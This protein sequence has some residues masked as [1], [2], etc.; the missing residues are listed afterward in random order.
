M[1]FI[2]RMAWRDT[3]A[4]RRRLLLYSSTIVLGIAALVAVGAFSVNVRKT[5]GDQPK[6]L[7]GS[8]MRVGLGAWPNPKFSAYLNSTG[9]RVAR[10]KLFSS[11]LSGPNLAPSRQSV[12]VVAIDGPFPF[13]GEFLAAP[14]EATARLR[15]GER[16]AIVDPRVA[17][18]YHLTIGSPITLTTGTYLVAGVVSDLPGESSLM[19]SLTGRVFVPWSTLGAEPSGAAAP[20]RGNYRLYLAWP[21]AVHLA[22]TAAEIKSRFAADFPIVMTSEELGKQ[23]DD[24][25]IAGSRFFSLVVFVALFLGAIGVATALQVYVQERLPSI[26]IL[27]CLGLGSGRA[28]LIYLL[29]AAGLGGCGAVGGGLLGL[30]VQFAL[31]ALIKDFF[32]VHLEVFFAWVPVVKGMAAGFGVCMVFTLLPLLPIRLVSPLA[33]LRSES[34]PRDARDPAR[35]LGWVLIAAAVAGFAR[36]ETQAWKPAL[37]YTLA[38]T[39]A[40]GV[41][42]ATALLVTIV[43]RQTIPSSLPFAIRHGAANLHRPHNRTTLLLVSL[44]LGLF[45]VLTIYLTRSTL[46]RDFAGENSPNLILS[47]IADEDVAGVTKAVTEQHLP[48]LRQIPVLSLKLESING[49]RFMPESPADRAGRRARLLPNFD[50]HA[51]G[52]IRGEL[53]RAETL[54]EG[55]FPARARSGEPVVPVTVAQWMSSG[56]AGPGQIFRVGDEAVWEVE[57]VALHTRI[58]GVRRHQGMAVEPNFAVVF[59]PGAVDGAPAKTLLFIRSPAP[60]ATA[61]L[62]NLLAGSFPRVRSFDIAVLLETVERVF[63]KVSLVVDFVAFFT[64]AT[65][66]I[67]LASAVVAGRHQRARESVLLRSLGATRRQLRTIQLV[68]YASVGLL[69]GLF[70]CGLAGLANF[71]L[72]KFLLKIPAGGGWGELALAAAVMVA[73]TVAT[74]VFA[75]RGLARLSPL[76][77]LREET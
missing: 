5:V 52:T 55:E 41:F 40:F 4:S 66:M 42:A 21:S 46:R 71:L 31:P 22:D 6:R 20:S 61:Q 64:V 17:E 34:G 7:L 57:G 23:V 68:E 36:L 2:L 65:G 28:M 50:G 53:L 45:L 67:I 70:G 24:A 1:N 37:Y 11:T 56:K 33:A 18:R 35:I 12:Q 47:D 14:R 9:A 76:E 32:P 15:R 63:A 74:G 60:A 75:D 13:Y 19:L 39:I 38:L 59:P 43:A 69:A 48:I 54:V 3:R 77:I 44:G 62:S 49:K 27:R 73:V 58:V 72:A 16:V 30:M 10:Q 8:D 29:Q 51:Q 26:A 25:I